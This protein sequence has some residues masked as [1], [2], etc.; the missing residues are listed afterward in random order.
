MAK[1]ETYRHGVPCWVDVAVADV[2]QASAFYGALF[3]WELGPDLGAEVG[4]YRMFEFKGAP[5][6]GVM[7]V[8]MTGAPP[9]WGVAI[10][11]DDLDAATAKVTELGGT[12][13][14]G[15]DD[16]PNGS[17]RLSLIA[18]PS[19]AMVTLWQAGWHH[20]SGYANEPGTLIWNDLNAWDLGPAL[21]FWHQLCGWDAGEAEPN[22]GYRMMTINGRAVCGAMTMHREQVPEGTPSHWL[23][24]FHVADT[25]A[26]V[27]LAE[28]MGASALVLPMDMGAGPMALLSAPDG[29]MFFVM[30][31]TTVDDPNE[32]AAT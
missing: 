5:V 27:A 22:S 25:A 13:M 1:V 14:M 23:N 19:G 7:L 26:T 18:D 32:W 16:V 24:Y 9:H 30:Q 31:P 8:E 20:G 29:A 2:E 15:P 6:A 21:E 10:N 11:V 3:G 12:V 17:G 28:S 4:H